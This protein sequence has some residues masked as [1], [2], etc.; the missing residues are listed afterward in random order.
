MV[1]NATKGNLKEGVA[2]LIDVHHYGGS[3]PKPHM[4][5]ASE[6]LSIVSL[7]HSS[8]SDSSTHSS[9]S[10]TITAPHTGVLVFIGR[11]CIQMMCPVPVA[12]TQYLAVPWGQTGPRDWLCRELARY[13]MSLQVQ[14]SPIVLNN[15]IY[16]K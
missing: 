12:V 4:T 14:G 8:S 10:L 2:T 5:L 9:C 15:Y 7:S 11:V 16:M 3:S 6:E 13:G 1:P